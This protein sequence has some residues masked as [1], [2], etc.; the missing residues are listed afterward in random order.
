MSDD[1]KKPPQDQFDFSDEDSLVDF[2]QEFHRPRHT[3]CDLDRSALVEQAQR[4]T[5]IEERITKLE[6][7]T[8]ML[9]ALGRRVFRYMS[10]LF[11]EK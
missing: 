2:P 5:R 4:L 7:L 9:L 6:S 8:S 10:T 11:G 3:L 1:N